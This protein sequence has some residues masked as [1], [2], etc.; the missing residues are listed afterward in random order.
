MSLAPL[1]VA[2][3]LLALGACSPAVSG[4]PS[5]AAPTPI[6]R[7]VTPGISV[8]DAEDISGRISFMVFGDPAELRAYQE[9][10]GAFER[11]HPEIDVE[12]IHIP[13]QSEYRQRLSVDFVAGTPANVVLL[14]YRRYADYA[15]GDMLE[16]LEPYLSTSTVIHADDF[17]A[18]A[19]AP[20]RWRRQLMCIPQNISSLVVYYN[21]NLF[22]A[23]GVPYPS[24]D[25]TR[26]DFL[27]IAQQLTKDTNGDG[28]SDQHGLGIEPSLIRLAPFIWQH[29]GTLVENP[30][31]PWGLAL[32]SPEAIRAAQWFVDLQVKYHVVPD[33]VEEKS[34]DSESRFLN[35][36]LAMLLNSRRGV[37]TYRTITAFD[38]DVALLPKYKG[39]R[40]G[41]LHADGYCMTALT[42]LHLKQASW[43]FIEFANSPE[44]Q[45]IVAT[46]GRTV[47][48]LTA[49][50]ESPA[51]LDP[52]AKPA[53]S[54]IF[55]T[56]IPSL[57]AVPVIENW[58]DIES[59]AGDEIERAFYGSVSVTEALQSA[60]VRTEEYFRISNP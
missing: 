10:V 37:P 56:S 50:A 47:P 28:R 53:H 54:R 7:Q 27:R 13:S 49:V 2:L 40:S 9:L 52:D 29:K 32:N 38:W 45:T 36:R 34:E 41:I 43:K 12:L 51:F 11:Q 35:G 26:D 5:A 18:K 55:L 57:R 58:G 46:T 4:E 19:I 20:F 39:R 15:A 42:P 17:Y 30:M 25:W 21:K 1:C 24:D 31:L 33:A 48:S 16:P 60:V 23:A 3:M 22:D 8:S 44:G 6:P 59:I 14:N